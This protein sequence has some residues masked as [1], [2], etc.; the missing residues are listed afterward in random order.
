VDRGGEKTALLKL[1]L[2]L[3]LYWALLPIA[4]S[5]LHTH[6]A[7]ALPVSLMQGLLLALNGVAG[8]LVGSQ[9]PLANRMWLQGKKGLRDGGFLYACD[10]LGAFLGSVVVSVVLIPVLGIPGTCLLAGVL[11]LTSFLVVAALPAPS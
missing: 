3:I 1:E 2:L 11:K 9:F 7:H 8:F 4:L 6:P 5:A 10:L